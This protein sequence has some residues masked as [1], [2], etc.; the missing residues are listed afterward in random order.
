LSQSQLKYALGSDTLYIIVWVWNQTTRLIEMMVSSP[1]IA[2]VHYLET[3]LGEEESLTALQSEKC[4]QET[5]RAIFA[6]IH[7]ILIA[8]LKQPSLKPAVCSLREGI[9]AWIQYQP[10]ALGSLSHTTLVSRLLYQPQAT[11]TPKRK[12]FEIARSWLPIF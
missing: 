12:G 11:T 10:Q 4:P 7:T 3:G 9:T 6:G 8:A 5:V 1:H 2:V